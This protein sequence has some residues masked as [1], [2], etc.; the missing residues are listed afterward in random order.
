MKRPKS[1]VD[2]PGPD[3]GHGGHGGGVQLP[4]WLGASCIL[5][6]GAMVFAFSLSDDYG[7]FLRE[8]FR[9]LTRFGA[10]VLLAMG[11]VS[12]RGGY[13]PRLTDVGAVGLLLAI[14][15]FG[16]PV[17]SRFVTASLAPPDV[18]VVVS[19][20]DPEFP[21]VDIRDLLRGLEDGSWHSDDPLTVIGMVQRLDDAGRPDEVAIAQ[22]YM[23][24][25]VADA[26][27]MG[28]RVADD[29]VNQFK[30]GQWI[31][32]RGWVRKKAQPDPIPLF[33][34]GMS[35]FTTTSP[36][37]VLTAS[38]IDAYD[39]T[40]YLPLIADRLS[41]SIPPSR[42]AQL[43]DAADLLDVLKADGPFTVFVPVDQAIE[44]LGADQLE[45]ESLSGWLRMH[46]ARGRF[47]EREL[48]GVESLTTIDGHRVEVTHSN[49]KLRIADARIV[50][51]DI[52]CR[53]GTVHL[54]YP[55]VVPTP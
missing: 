55:A 9:W 30:D 1:T 33:R 50:F 53:N 11:G 52:Q 13:R 38:T 12:I 41:G 34:M 4:A 15:V 45:A 29:R 49:G 32:V 7:R 5:I 27:G 31:I 37:H 17:S 3:Y 8:E 36:D 6:I 51:A 26:F 48:F 19:L 42:F 35:S 22:S 14:V 40:A 16:R 20:D 46:I 39:A 47:T 44:S 10:V 18:P 43:L 28:L 24:C 2:H 21:L 23:V 25:C 54:V